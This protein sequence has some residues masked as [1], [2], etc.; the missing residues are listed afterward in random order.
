MQLPRKLP[1][2]AKLALAAVFLITAA[3]LFFPAISSRF[4]VYDEK[5]NEIPDIK[6]TDPR[7]NFPQ[8]GKD[9]CAP[10]VVVDSFAWLQKHGYDRILGS[11]EVKDPEIA[12]CRKLAGMMATTPGTGTTTENFLAGLQKY[13]ST[14]TP[15]ALKSLK[16]EGWNRHQRE[17]GNAADVPDLEWIKA[18]IRGNNCA[19]LNIGWYEEDRYTN[20]LVRTDG[21]W[22][23]LIGYGKENGGAANSSVIIVHDPD[24]VLSKEPRSIFIKLEALKEGTLRGPHQGLPRSA[25]GYFRARPAGNG[26]DP[27]R[28]R[29]GIIDGVIVLELQPP[30][31]DHSKPIEY[32]N[33]PGSVTKN[34]EAR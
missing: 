16:Y 3:F 22:V 17:F 14:G 13:I 8:Q 27:T 18:G 21:H 30:C 29:T 2:F 11:P 12:A 25:S 28:N 24:P 34:A 10:V 31:N 26:A 7:L 32:N 15:Y 1:L 19:W 33:K 20:S 6:Q 4:V 5:I 23:A 9:F